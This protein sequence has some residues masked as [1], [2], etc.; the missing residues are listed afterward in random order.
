M[1]G[2]GRKIIRKGIKKMNKYAIILA[3]GQGTRFWPM[4]RTKYPKQFLTLVGNRSLLQLTFDRISKVLPNENIYIV[5]AEDQVD[6]IREQLP[7]LR[8]KQIIVEPEGRN[9][10]PA[11]ALGVAYIKKENE[12]ATIFVSPSD[13]LIKDEETFVSIVNKAIDYSAKKQEFVVFGI[14]PDSPHTG[15]G[16]IKTK[17]SER[18]FS[19]VDSFVEKPNEETAQQYLDEGNYYWNSG[20]FVF[21]AKLFF[22]E[23]SKHLPGVSSD[24]VSIYNSLGTNEANKTINSIYP[25]IE[26]VSID[27]GIMEKLERIAHI[28]LNVGWNDVGSWSSLY[29]ILD[30]DS[31]GNI[32]T[33]DDSISI[34]SKNSIGFTKK[35]VA[36]VG[37]EDLI[38]VETEESILVCNKNSAQSV[39]KVIDIYKEKGLDKLL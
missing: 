20:M 38:I 8:D 11:I 2:N 39:K 19:V 26:R 14:D 12:N 3:G 5:T 23:L 15:Y 6:I 17:Q 10:C 4:S 28:S 24:I 13:H 32:R 18:D 37:V 35:P 25:S 7:E 30:G 29:D 1:H 33:N 34:D 9:T 27:Y 16:Y 36:M 21:G 22:D 31:N